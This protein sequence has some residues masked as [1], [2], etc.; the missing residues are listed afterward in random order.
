MTVGF[1]EKVE[2]RTAGQSRMGRNRR[3]PRSFSFPFDCSSARRARALV[4]SMRFH[5]IVVITGRLGDFFLGI[6][7]DRIADFSC[8]GN[9]LIGP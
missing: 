6:A 8:L 5:A 3:E 7:I 2:L 9:S 4:I 1:L